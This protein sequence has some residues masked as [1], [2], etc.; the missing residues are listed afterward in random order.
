MTGDPGPEAVIATAGHVDHGKTALTRAL[1]GTDADR[2]PE[3]RR[4]GMTLDLG[5]ATTL[6]PSGRR[7]ALVDVPGHE[8]LVATML[9]GAGPAG[10]VLLVVAADGGWSAQTQEHVALL[11]AL[12]VS[13]AVVALTRCDLAEPGR[14]AD[15]AADVRRRLAATSL[16]GSPVVPVSART[17]EGLGD[18]TRALDRLAA[19]VLAAAGAD[20]R[21][22]TPTRLWVDRVVTVPGAGC[23]VTG[24]LHG[25]LTVGD[26]LLLSE[27]AVSVRG[28][29]RHGSAVEVARGPARVAVSLRGARASEV[30]RGD[31]LTDCE[32]WLA[33]STL[34]VRVH[35]TRSPATS[36][37]QPPERLPRQV[38]VHAGT[39]AVTGHVRRLGEHHARLRVERPVPLHVG[40]TVVLRDPGSRRAVAA[41]VLDTEPAQLVRHGDVRRRVEMLQE[42]DPSSVGHVDRVGSATPE[43]LR[44]RGL[45]PLDRPLLDGR[46]VADGL[47]D[48]AAS[49]AR[50]GPL[51]ASL[52]ATWPDRLPT[53]RA[54]ERE[55]TR[56]AGLVVDGDRLRAAS[57]SE[58]TVPAAAGRTE[59]AARLAAAL[60]DAETFTVADVRR[61]LDVPR[62][63]AV[64]LLERLA[65][66][67]VTRRRA[68]GTHTW[69]RR[70]L[71]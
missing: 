34:D 3:E 31:W 33:V 48:Q 45:D 47:L 20:P 26:R 61:A 53:G 32:H 11:S 43:D 50:P 63:D 29:Q 4:R 8:R 71:G 17:G 70:P 30:R 24:T 64:R 51:P 13:D 36:S 60:G 65:G 28:L 9:A 27:R 2:L 69:V 49:G 18:L 67:G 41:V 42:W 57:A 12:G 19:D 56:R 10:G 21:P 25:V 1:T 66:S 16:A 22:P 54:V 68:D 37:D 62:G 59:P 23:V 58:G 35:H 38:T 15:V 44:R 52:R 5:V 55:V 14:A 7:L 40:E 6:L 39:E 46:W